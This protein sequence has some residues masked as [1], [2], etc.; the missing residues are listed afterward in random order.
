MRERFVIGG[1]H[2][3]PAGMTQRRRV[4]CILQHLVAGT[5]NGERRAM[6]DEIVQRFGKKVHAL[7]FGQP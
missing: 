2:A 1:N 5:E 6:G 7:L 4:K 3:D